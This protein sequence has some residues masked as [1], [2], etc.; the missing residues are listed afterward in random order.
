MELPFG[1]AVAAATVTCYLI[2]H[3]AS[4]ESSAG[5]GLG[6]ADKGVGS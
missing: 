2:G 5:D 3:I 1:V 6:A 4:F